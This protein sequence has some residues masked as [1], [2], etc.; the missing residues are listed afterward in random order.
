LRD[1][2]EAEFAG[3]PIVYVLGVSADKP[4]REMARALMDGPVRSVVLTVADNP[5]SMA[6]RDLRK[7]VAPEAG[8]VDLW[9][10]P[11]C[12]EALRT[13]EGLAGEDGVVC[14]AGSL[15]LVGEAMVALGA[16]DA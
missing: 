9:E 16:A 2:L 14:V 5:R 1:A 10:R 7:A 13:A 3:R 6:V 15:Y 8:G 12:T 11:T 4:A